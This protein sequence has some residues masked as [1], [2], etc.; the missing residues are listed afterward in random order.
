MGSG[1]TSMARGWRCMLLCLPCRSTAHCATAMTRLRVSS[2]G[3][4]ASARS[5][6]SCL[7]HS[8]LLPICDPVRDVLRY[9]CSAKHQHGSNDAE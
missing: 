2:A 5:P 3:S 7:L 6:C 8:S 4:A 1:C 9:N